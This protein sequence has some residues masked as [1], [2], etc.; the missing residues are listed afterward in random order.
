[1]PFHL[2]RTKK[3]SLSNPNRESKKTKKSSSKPRKLLNISSPS[4]QNS[5]YISTMLNENK[6]HNNALKNAKQKGYYNNQ[7]LRDYENEFIEY[8]KNLA[9][10][11]KK[12]GK[13]SLTN[14]SGKEV[15]YTLSRPR[16]PILKRPQLHR[17]NHTLSTD[18]NNNNNSDFEEE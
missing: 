6:A 17:P 10:F 1:M 8:K 7:S 4:Q 9:N 11:I 3:Y 18:Y 14:S 16:R 13:Y 12:E 5:N 2:F 15:K